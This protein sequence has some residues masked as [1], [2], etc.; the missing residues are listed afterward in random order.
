MQFSQHYKSIKDCIRTNFWGSL[1][2]G[3][4]RQSFRGRNHPGLLGNPLNEHWERRKPVISEIALLKPSSIFHRM[5]PVYPSF[6]PCRVI[7]IQLGRMRLTCSQESCKSFASVITGHPTCKPTF[8]VDD[9]I[10]V[11]FPRYEAK[12]DHEEVLMRQINQIISE[13]YSLRNN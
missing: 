12:D 6:H 11:I 8:S 5:K 7:G 9:L 2:G 3:W 1:K 4:K 13:Y 10:I